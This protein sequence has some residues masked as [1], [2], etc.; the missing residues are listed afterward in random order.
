MREEAAQV[1]RAAEVLGIAL[2]KMTSAAMIF[3]SA[4]QQWEAEAGAPVI[5][6]EASRTANTASQARDSAPESR[7]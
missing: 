4:L 1:N 2:E 3:A 7:R 5:S 6:G